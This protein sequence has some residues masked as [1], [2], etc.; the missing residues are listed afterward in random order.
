MSRAR[1]ARFGAIE[2][3]E[4]RDPGVDQCG[5]SAVSLPPGVRVVKVVSRLSSAF[6]SAL[7]IVSCLSGCATNEFGEPTGALGDGAL[8]DGAL[9][10]SAKTMQEAQLQFT[11]GNYGLAVDAYAKAVERD[12]KNPE[13]WLGLAASY[14]Q[15][16]RFDMADKAYAR[17]QELVGATPSVL[18]NLGYSYLLRGNLKQSRE[19]LAAAHKLDPGNPYILN[20]IDTL[21]DRLAALKQPPLV[22]Q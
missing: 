3:Q 4:H 22:V 20:N 8:V 7:F 5:L 2:T 12:P 18:N 1:V 14:D 6:L 13:G 19:T 9:P 16:G 15:V 11:Q 10:Q 17:T 21:N